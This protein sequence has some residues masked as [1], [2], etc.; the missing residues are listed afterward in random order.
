MILLS[1]TSGQRKC[2]APAAFQNHGKCD[3]GSFLRTK[4]K[5]FKLLRACRAANKPPAPCA[6]TLVT[7]SKLEA[8]RGQQKMRNHCKPQNELPPTIMLATKRP[9]GIVVNSS[10]TGEDT[11]RGGA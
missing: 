4:G 1:P 9:Q 7:K 3:S 5:L 10:E 11:G 6:V 8:L 2:Q